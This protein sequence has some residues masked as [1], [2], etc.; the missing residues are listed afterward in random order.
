VSLVFTLAPQ[1]VVLG[2]IAC[3]AGEELCFAPVR[4]RVRART[5]PALSQDLQILG[6][7]L[8]E[9]TADLAG[10]CAGLE[11]LEAPAVRA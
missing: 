11:A 5:W 8:G 10:I 9:R 1:A 6:A 7:A 4:E 3:A 2:T